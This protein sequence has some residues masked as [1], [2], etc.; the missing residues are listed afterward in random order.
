MRAASGG[1]ARH[2]R[3]A[4][5]LPGSLSEVDAPDDRYVHRLL[6]L[7]A[8]RS[9]RAK[10]LVCMISFFWFCCFACGADESCYHAVSPCPCPCL[11]RPLRPH[12]R[13]RLLALSRPQRSMNIITMTYL[14][15]T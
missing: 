9:S 15:D 4:R 11:H 5:P 12:R 8:S 3:A 14:F 7:P 1:S 13:Y 2:H 6:P 10:Q